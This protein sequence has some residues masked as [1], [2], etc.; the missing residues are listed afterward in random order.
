MLEKE[1]K[2]CQKHHQKLLNQ[3][4]GRYVVV[5]DDKVIGDYA[6]E[7]K[8]YTKTQKQHKLGTFLIQMISPK[9]ENL[10]QKFSSRVI[11]T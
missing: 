5:R 11:F 9:K 7:I 3:F 4:N 6:T 2:Y 8:A 1:F 10:A